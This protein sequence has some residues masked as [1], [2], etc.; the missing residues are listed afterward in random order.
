MI[1]VSDSWL[2]NVRSVLM[3]GPIPTPPARN[4]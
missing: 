3:I 2:A 4:T 1:T